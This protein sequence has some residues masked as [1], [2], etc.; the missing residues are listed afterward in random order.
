MLCRRCCGKCGAWRSCAS[1]CLQQPLALQGTND[2]YAGRGKDSIARRQGCHLGLERKLGAGRCFM[3]MLFRMIS[4]LSLTKA[5]QLLHT[6]AAGESNPPASHARASLLRLCRWCAM[7]AAAAAAPSDHVHEAVEACTYPTAAPYAE[8]C[9][10][11]ARSL[12][13]PLQLA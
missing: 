9:A 13:G 3:P 6:T 4:L 11:A 5:A 1:G 12:D 10:P 2:C 8:R 7:A